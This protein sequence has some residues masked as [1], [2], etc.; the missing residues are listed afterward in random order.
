MKIHIL[1]NFV[2]TPFI[3]RTHTTSI[4]TQTLSVVLNTQQ[5]DPER[6]QTEHRLVQSLDMRNIQASLTPSLSW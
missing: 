2:N 3:S 1:E 4:V 6:N 5:K